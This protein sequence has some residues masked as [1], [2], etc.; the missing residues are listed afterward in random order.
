MPYR[1]NGVPST[2]IPDFI[3]ELDSGLSL[4]VETKGQYN[5][6]ADMKAKAAER[7]V[8]AVNE[9]GSFGLWRYRVVKEPA[10][11]PNILNEFCVAKWD[12]THLEV[13]T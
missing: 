9:A 13:G 1:K 2:Y 8:N 6:N 10:E 3:V 11:L 5:D 4:I 7:W 12:A